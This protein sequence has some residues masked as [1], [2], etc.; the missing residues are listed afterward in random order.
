MRRGDFNSC[1]GYETN[2]SSDHRYFQTK[3]PDDSQNWAKSKRDQENLFFNQADFGYVREIRR[4]LRSFC[5]PDSESQDASKLEC[6]RFTRFCRGR[7]IYINFSRIGKVPEPMKYRDDV[8]EDG[9]IGGWECKLKKKELM[10]EGEH[11]SPLQSWF[12][13]IEHFT[14]RDIED[15][16]CDVTIEKPTFL[17]KLDATI[18]MYHH[19]CDFLN[20]YLTLHVNSS[21]NFDNNILIWDTGRYNSNFGI[22]WKA[23]TDHEIMHLTPFRGLYSCFFFSIPLL[24][25]TPFSFVSEK[26]V[27]FKDIVFPLLPRMVFGMY[28][29]MPLVPGCYGSGVFHAFRRHVL[30]RLRVKV[31]PVTEGMKK[32]RITI[33]DRQTRHRNILNIDELIES[34]R[35]KNKNFVVKKVNFHH[36]MPF[37]DQLSITANT[38]ILIGMHGAGLTHA[39]FL[40]DDGVLFELYNCDDELCYKDL[41]RLR[42]VKYMT[43]EKETMLHPQDAGHHPQM[44]A[45]KKFTNYTFDK[46]E[47]LRLVM[48]AVR[49]VRSGR[50]KPS[51]ASATRRR[52]GEL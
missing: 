26:T 34:V 16:K 50:A 20:L 42:G 18:N 24:S 43:W 12:E 14:V 15:V 45:H 31:D 47:F 17:M 36:R 10:R 29:N 5:D 49:Q 52:S 33:I 25:S 4:E 1:W 8:L 22:T 51:D 41:A 44:G 23:F 3:C 6:S 7:N 37:L 35:K 32:I 11:R 2:C 9:Q 30:H 39:L 27:C 38:D 21:F 46:D 40:P 13:E 48:I 28:Y 19:F